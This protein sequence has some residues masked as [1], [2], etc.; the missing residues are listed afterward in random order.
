MTI[1][2]LDL[3]TLATLL[4]HGKVSVTSPLITIPADGFAG[5]VTNCHIFDLSTLETFLV[6]GR[7]FDIAAMTD[8]FAGLVA[9]CHTFDLST[10]ETFLVR[11]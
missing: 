9:N 2:R 10:L 3:A 11:G 6:L 7:V 4:V 5:L 8:G 1:H